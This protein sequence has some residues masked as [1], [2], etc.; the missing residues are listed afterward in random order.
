MIDFMLKKYFIV[1]I[2]LFFSSIT[3]AQSDS[4]TNSIDTSNSSNSVNIENTP[5]ESNDGITSGI[6]VSPA[7]FQQQDPTRPP[8]DQTAP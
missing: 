7:H 8:C 1:I 3:F 2:A 4:I 6:S 5:K